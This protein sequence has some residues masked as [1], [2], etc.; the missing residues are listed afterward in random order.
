M[1]SPLQGIDLARAD[2]GG[3]V[4]AA[5]DEFFAAKEN[6]ILAA[7]AVFDNDDYYDRGKRMDGWETRRRRT[8]GYDWAVIR[9]AMPGMIQTFVIDTS[10][11]TGNYPPGA[12]V[13]GAYLPG[14][15]SPSEVLA[16]DVEW[17]ALTPRVDL[18]GDT[19]NVVEATAHHLVT[20]VRL[21]IYPDGGVARLRAFGTPCAPWSKLGP[22]PDLASAVRGARVVAVS[23]E[24]YGV[25]HNVLMPNRS[26]WMKDGWEV[27]RRRDDGNDWCLIR[28]A[29]PGRIR[30]AEIDTNHFK[31]NCPR[32][33]R[34]EAARWPGALPANPDDIPWTEL[35]PMFRTQPHTQHLVGD[36][37]PADAGPFDLLRVSIYPDGGISR[38]RM[39][40]DP[41]TDALEAINVEW[42]NRMLPGT[43]RQTLTDCCGSR[44]WV[45]HMM[46]AAPWDSPAALRD[47]ADA[48]W[49]ATSE[50]D[51]LE[52]FS[53]HPRIGDKRV[54]AQSDAAA[55]L[56]AA[57]QSG[58]ANAAT[59]TLDQLASLNESYTDAFGFTYIVCATGRSAGD[60][61]NL[62]KKR[63]N[64]ARPEELEV[65]AAE[66]HKI[67]HI[68]LTKALS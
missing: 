19:K 37:F 56:S 4:I 33:V 65:A 59:D 12:S 53:H 18:D 9:L 67:T 24:F 47:D 22:E 44:Q 13:E 30:R 25:R 2:L 15:P 61:L 29:V 14:Y 43:L 40:G 64:N 58:T 54:K 27:R 7:E 31:G 46:D 23:D 38:L 28:L 10:H 3:M 62:L 66:Q 55:A 49:A 26:V 42:L 50:P 68:R 1:T 57:E 41:D 48:A 20:H 17:V 63:I 36:T 32:A 51:W 35:L 6:L 16:D 11:F 5:N 60:M 21:N 34:I 52:A 45:Q 39:W 8:K